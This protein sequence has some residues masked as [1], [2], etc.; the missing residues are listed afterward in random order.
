MLVRAIKVIRS[1]SLTGGTHV[2]GDVAEVHSTVADNLGRKLHF[3]VWQ[4]DGEHCTILH[5]D[6]EEV[7]VRDHVGLSTRV[8]FVAD[9]ATA[10]RAVHDEAAS[11]SPVQLHPVRLLG[12]Q[13]EEPVGTFGP[14]TFGNWL[15]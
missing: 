14:F 8:D 15:S 1:S 2:P 12:E 13:A 10:N 6:V 11:S 3:V 4:R 9:A 7:E 5:T